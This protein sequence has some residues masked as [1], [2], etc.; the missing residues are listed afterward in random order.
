MF[1]SNIFSRNEKLVLIVWMV[2]KISYDFEES[3]IMI[4]VYRFV[5]LTSKLCVKLAEL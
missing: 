4:I 5:L 2:G 3:E 1:N